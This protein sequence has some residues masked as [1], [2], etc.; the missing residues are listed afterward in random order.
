MDVENKIFLIEKFLTHSLTK[1]EEQDFLRWLD[2]DDRN[3]KLVERIQSKEEVQKRLDYFKHV[4]EEKGWDDIKR[5]CDFKKGRRITL[6]SMLRYAAMI[7]VALGVYW[8]LRNGESRKMELVN[9]ER[10]ERQADENRIVVELADGQCLTLGDSSDLKQGV[11]EGGEFSEAK[12]GLRFRAR[13]TEN[14][15]TKMNRIVVPRGGEYQIVLSDGTKVWLNADTYLVFPSAFDKRER[16]VEV[17]GEAFF[18]VVHNEGW[19]FVVR[20]DK[21]MV[22][23]LGT[24]FNINTYNQRNTTTLAEGVVELVS[25]RGNYRLK[26][27]EQGVVENGKVSVAT[28]DVREYT[29]WKDGF[30]IFRNRRLEDVLTVLSRWYDLQVSY[31]NDWMKDLHFTGNIRKHADVW[32]LL[33]FWEGTGLVGFEIKGKTLKVFEK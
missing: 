16:V 9:G 23:V 11:F 20:M 3:R 5:Q 4:D 32:Q 24:S 15:Q 29:S 25:E 21:S 17:A 19:P 33:K 6:K 14:Q 27:G 30:F 22:K 18:E 2:E 26:P 12:D 31:Q 1:E 28:V 10:M 7:V 13:K 8:M